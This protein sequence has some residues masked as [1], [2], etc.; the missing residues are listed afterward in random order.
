[1]TACDSVDQEMSVAKCHGTH[2][3]KPLS[4]NSCCGTSV[5]YIY[6][7][8]CIYIC[9]YIYIYGMAPGSVTLEPFMLPDFSTIKGNRETSIGFLI[10]IFYNSNNKI[11][12]YTILAAIGH[13]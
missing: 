3:A 12:F 1:M 7:Y 9:I 11:E 6:I 8:M 4:P 13:A 5:I 2:V 10:G